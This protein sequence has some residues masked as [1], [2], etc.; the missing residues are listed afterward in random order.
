MTHR[1]LIV[2]HGCGIGDFVNLQPLA[3]AIVCARPEACIDV[4]GPPDLAVLLPSSVRIVPWVAGIPYWRRTGS[5]RSSKLSARLVTSRTAGPLAD[6]FPIPSITRLMTWY[7]QRAGFDEVFNFLEVFAACRPGER[8]TQGSWNP[9][10]VHLVDVLANHLEMRGI[11]LPVNARQPI[12]VSSEHASHNTVVLLQVGAGN[13]LKTLPF[14]HWNALAHDLLRDGIRVGVLSSPSDDRGER[15]AR[16]APGLEV[17]RTPTIDA[18]VTAL[19]KA[20]LVV[21]PD[22]GVLHIAAALGIPFLGLFGPTDPRF[23]GPYLAQPDSLL[24]ASAAHARACRGCWAAQMLPT[25][26]CGMGYRGGCMASL[27]ADTIAETVR[28]RL[29]AHPP[30]SVTG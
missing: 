2:P 30:S 11:P 12:L 24:Q 16:S 15:L 18:L 14:S 5:A 28:W 20:R 26:G 6:M 1:V 9:P 27:G 13:S 21:S 25:A 19:G 7:L 23:L 17:I 29:S 3:R 8:W 4:L 22:T 10:P